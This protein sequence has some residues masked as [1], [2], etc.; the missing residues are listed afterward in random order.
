MPSCM[1]CGIISDDEIQVGYWM[2]TY[3][4]DMKLIR[5]QC[6]DCVTLEGLERQRIMP[7]FQHEHNTLGTAGLKKVRASSEVLRIMSKTKDWLRTEQVKEQLPDFHEETTRAALVSL[8][9]KGEIERY[10]NGNHVEWRA[11]PGALRRQARRDKR[12]R[13]HGIREAYGQ[14]G[15]SKRRPSRSGDWG[16]VEV[17]GDLLGQIDPSST[18]TGFD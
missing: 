3:N 5:L 9:R 12:N 8:H 17:L 7:G 1:D 14:A 18:D 11:G 2:K 16:G 10:K 6:R 15:A 13:E 4:K